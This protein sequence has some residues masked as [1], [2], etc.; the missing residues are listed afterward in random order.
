M[1]IDC[2]IIYYYYQITRL[3]HQLIKN[4]LRHSCMHVFAWWRTHMSDITYATMSAPCGKCFPEGNEESVNDKC[5]C[6]DAEMFANGATTLAP[7]DKYTQAVGQ[8]LWL[9]SH[10]VQPHQHHVASTH[11]RTIKNL[12]TTD[13]FV[14]MQICARLVQLH[15]HHAAS[16]HQKTIRNLWMMMAMGVP[17]SLQAVHA[18]NSPVLHSTWTACF[19]LTHV[20]SC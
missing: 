11:Q 2:G 13:Q 15:Q 3:M 16:T 9:P 6:V 14:L 4:G 1:H 10:F 20:N 17:R 18:L 19:C 8:F 5:F 7:C 12:W